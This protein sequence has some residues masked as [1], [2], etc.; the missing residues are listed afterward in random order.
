MTLKSVAY[1]VGELPLDHP[2]YY[3]FEIRVECRNLAEGQWAIV[4]RADVWSRSTSSW[5]YEPLSSGRTDEWLADHRFSRAEA[6]LIATRLAPGLTVN[7]F[8]V[9][10]ALRDF[11]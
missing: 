9:T 3:N 6:I 11:S 7:G 1:S 4:R 10:D 8:T 2:E 5:D